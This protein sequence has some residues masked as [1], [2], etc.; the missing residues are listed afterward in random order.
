MLNQDLPGESTYN[1]TMD[2]N[3]GDSEERLSRTEVLVENMILEQDSNE[4]RYTYMEEQIAG[5][6]GSIAKILS[7]LSPSSTS[8]TLSTDYVPSFTSEKTHSGTTLHTGTTLCTGNLRPNTSLSSGTT[9]HPI[10][11]KIP[12]TP[13]IGE[14]KKQIYEHPDFRNHYRNI[15]RPEEDP[16][17][18]NIGITPRSN[19]SYFQRRL[20]NCSSA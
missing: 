9:L 1:G 7:I 12:F 5:I 16:P 15:F 2:G 14:E 6:Q 20:S 17:S 18:P 19:L 8:G 10:S 4:V 3:I 11:R 13:T